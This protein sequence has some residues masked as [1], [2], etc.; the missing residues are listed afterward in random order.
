MDVVCDIALLPVEEDGRGQV[1]IQGDNKF[2]TRG[3][4]WSVGL[5]LDDN[6]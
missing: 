3:F 6:R 2:I 1:R 4:V 5:G